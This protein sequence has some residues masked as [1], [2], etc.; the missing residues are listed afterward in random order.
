MKVNHLDLLVLGATTTTTTATTAG[1][2]LQILGVAVC[3]DGEED[4]VEIIGSE[5]D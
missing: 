4:R 5:A 2:L 1:Y 3:D